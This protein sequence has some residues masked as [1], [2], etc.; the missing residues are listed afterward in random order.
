M[1]SM[2]EMHLVVVW[3]GGVNGVFCWPKDD[4]K[5]DSWIGMNL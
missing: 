1:D 3:G 4:Y 2:D 5:F